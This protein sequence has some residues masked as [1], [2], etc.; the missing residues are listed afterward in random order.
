METVSGPADC[1][2][3]QIISGVEHA[4]IVYSWSDAIA[5][6]PLDPVVSGHVLVVPKV[7]VR[8]AVESPAVT[9]FAMARASELAAAYSAS[10]ILTSVGAAATQSVFHLHIHV[11][12]RL[13][14]DQ[15]MIPWGTT[16]D[17]HAA[18]ESRLFTVKTLVKTASG[19]T[20]C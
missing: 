10:N 17:P 6:T 15:L 3:C 2:F 4:E 8:D 13:T 19:S 7:H 20:S 11:I 5:F 18:R 1:V 12:P 9:A 16:G 14:G